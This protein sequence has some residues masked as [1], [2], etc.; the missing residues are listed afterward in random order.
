M[1]C[2]G[3]LEPEKMPP[4]ERAAYFHGLRAHLQII[5]W[6]LLDDEF[7]LKPEDWGWQLKNNTLVPT[8]TDNEVAPEC[9]LKVVR[10]KCKSSSKNQCGSNLCTCRKHGLNCVATCGGCRGEECNNREVSK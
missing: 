4:T 5:T 7:Q 6:K 8:E 2:K 1:V 3:V 9:L 10:C